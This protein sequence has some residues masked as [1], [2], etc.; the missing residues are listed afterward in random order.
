MVRTTRTSTAGLSP[1]WDFLL[2]L[3]H[4]EGARSSCLGENRE[5]AWLRSDYFSFTLRKGVHSGLE[6][7]TEWIGYLQSIRGS[8][9]ASCSALCRSRIRAGAVHR[10]RAALG[11][12]T[13]ALCWPGQHPLLLTELLEE[14][15]AGTGCF[16]SPGN[17]L[18]G[19]SLIRSL[20][21]WHC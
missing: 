10:W 15:R 18:Q 3:A 4:K 16:P 9:A 17:A 5:G 14:Q 12:V 2:P 13:A 1:L 20:P 7:L 8:M 19:H 6:K 11:R 21:L